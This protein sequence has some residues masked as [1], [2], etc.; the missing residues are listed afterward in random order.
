MGEIDKR[1]GAYVR[2]SQVLQVSP[3]G[4]VTIPNGRS[5]DV[6]GDLMVD[7]TLTVHGA[8]QRAVTA[9]GVYQSATNFALSTSMVALASTTLVVPTGMTGVSI[10]ATGRVYSLN[11]NTTGGSN[12]TGGD[13]IYAQVNIGGVT[14]Y[15][16]PTGISGSGGFATSVASLTSVVTGLTAGATVVVAVNGASGYAAIAANASNTAELSASVLWFN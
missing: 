2:A 3:M 1:I 12:G 5:L 13:A 9:G 11:P 6:S 14:G 15:G 10:T 8:Q 4:D 7:G 16:L